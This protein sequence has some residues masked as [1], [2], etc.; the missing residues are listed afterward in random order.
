MLANQSGQGRAHN[1][2]IGGAPKRG[3]GSKEEVAIAFSCD[4]AIE[5][6]HHAAVRGAPQ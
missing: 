6:G 4:P 3:Q 1:G 5:H 2:R